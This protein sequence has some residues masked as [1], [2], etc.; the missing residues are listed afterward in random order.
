MLLD[1]TPEFAARIV[2]WFESAA[3]LDNGFG[4]EDREAIKALF[5]LLDDNQV[6]TCEQAGL[7]FED[8]DYG[9]LDD[10]TFDPS[11]DYAAEDDDGEGDDHNTFIDNIPDEHYGQ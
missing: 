7:D 4:D 11:F 3:I 10:D 2:S 1:I 8:R 9:E 6:R 5:P